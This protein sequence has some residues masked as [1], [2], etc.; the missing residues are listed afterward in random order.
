MCKTF[1]ILLESLATREMNRELG[2]AA[3]GDDTRERRT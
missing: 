3:D 1:D 2:P